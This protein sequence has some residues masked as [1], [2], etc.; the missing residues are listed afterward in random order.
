[1]LE[2]T[3]VLWSMLYCDRGEFKKLS[4]LL[5]TNK[6]FLDSIYHKLVECYYNTNKKVV[7]MLYSIVKLEY[8]KNKDTTIT[9]FKDKT[10]P[11]YT[12]QQILNLEKMFGAHNHHLKSKNVFNL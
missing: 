10:E 5:L 9:V 6:K 4:E 3:L 7:G 12:D 2:D 8:Q 11:M 1:M